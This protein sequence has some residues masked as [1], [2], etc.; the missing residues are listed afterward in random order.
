ML[1]KAKTQNWSRLY[2]SCLEKLARTAI[3][4]QRKDVDDLAKNSPEILA[5]LAWEMRKYVNP[6]DEDDSDQQDDDLEEDEGLG[7]IKKKPKKPSKID[8]LEEDDGPGKPK[9]KPLKRK[10]KRGL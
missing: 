8:D 9:K 1:T 4:L 5:D 7:P 3:L 6:N 2:S 10:G